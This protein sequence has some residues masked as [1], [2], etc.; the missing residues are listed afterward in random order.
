MRQWQFIKDM[1][2]DGYVTISDVWLW[3]NWL[4]FLPGDKIIH[5]FLTAQDPG[6]RVFFEI[7]PEFYGG[8]VSGILSA[9]VWFLAFLLFSLLTV[10]NESVKEW[11]RGKIKKSNKK[12]KTLFL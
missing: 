11:F 6:I 9:L 8:W 10:V 2:F 1:N 12:S 7:T 5:Y 4:F 3:I